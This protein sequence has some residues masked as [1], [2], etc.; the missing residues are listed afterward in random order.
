MIQVRTWFPRLSTYPFFRV[1]FAR[2]APQDA[3]FFGLL[4]N[5][6]MGE[7]GA[8][9]C[10]HILPSIGKKVK[11]S[12]ETLS[13]LEH[14]RDQMNL[15]TLEDTISELIKNYRQGTLE[16]A[17]GSTMNQTLE[18]PPSRLGKPSN[19]APSKM[20]KLWKTA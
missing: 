4:P 14:L 19:P 12:R 6:L 8:D 16:G 20:K 10:W 15:A 3:D 9:V 1:D 18:T 17:F 2:A 7:R 11:I 5:S 13:R